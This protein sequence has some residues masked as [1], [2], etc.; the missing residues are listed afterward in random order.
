MVMKAQVRNCR[1]NFEKMKIFVFMVLKAQVR[2][3]E[4]RG[5]EKKKDFQNPLEIEVTGLD[6]WQQ[7]RKKS[8]FLVLWS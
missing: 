1:V 5:H 8:K 6:L 7:F 4:L 3:C 2:T